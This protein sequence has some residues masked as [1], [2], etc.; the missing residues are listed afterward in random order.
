MGN[1]PSA[2]EDFEFRQQDIRRERLLREAFEE[3]ERRMDRDLF[4]RDDRI[5]IL[6]EERSYQSRQALSERDRRIT[7]GGDKE[8]IES[9]YQQQLLEINA[10]CER[11]VQKMEDLFQK[12]KERAEFQYLERVNKIEIEYRERMTQTRN[13]LAA[14][15]NTNT[16]FT[17]LPDNIVRT[18]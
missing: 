9:R 12:H 17:I 3:R 4:E 6:R 16:P 11:D 7:T 14:F 5:S 10:R 15:R 8:I 2:A 13:N 1:N 18:V